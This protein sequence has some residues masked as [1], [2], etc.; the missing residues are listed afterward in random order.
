MNYPACKVLIEARKVEDSLDD[1]TV[2]MRRLRRALRQCDTCPEKHCP[3]LVEFSA[4]IQTAI[5]E[6]TEEWHL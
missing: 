4:A 6:L 2:H 1:L 5:A 3:L